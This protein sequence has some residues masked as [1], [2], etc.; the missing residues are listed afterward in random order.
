MFPSKF[1]VSDRI[2]QIYLETHMKVTNDLN[3]H[4]IDKFVVSC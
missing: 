4:V 1:I 2:V 3:M